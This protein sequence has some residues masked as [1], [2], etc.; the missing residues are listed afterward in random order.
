MGRY[1]DTPTKTVIRLAN[2]GDKDACMELSLRY[3]TGTALLEKNPAKAEYWRKQSFIDYSGNT[4]Y[5]NGEKS[6]SESNQA[7]MKQD[8]NR[9]V[10]IEEYDKKYDWAI[11]PDKNKHEYVIGIDFGHGETSAAFCPI[12]WD[13]A[14][15]ELETVKDID[16]G[17]NRKVLPSAINIQ[18]DGQAFL[19]DAA[20]SPERLKK[21]TVEVLFKK[22]GQI[23]IM[24]LIF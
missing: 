18:P 21:A 10:D 5:S 2:N 17:A 22:L 4:S 7:T 3:S 15:E 12:G 24:P 14:S 19:G 13:L 23:F 6:Y 9:M 1:T 16:F 11:I 20:F 8:E